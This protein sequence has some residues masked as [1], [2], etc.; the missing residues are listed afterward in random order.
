MSININ[1]NNNSIT[2]NFLLIFLFYA[3]SLKRHAHKLKTVFNN[4]QQS[5]THFTDYSITYIPGFKIINTNFPD[6]TAH[7]GIVIYVK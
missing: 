7:S 2:I 1:N 5:E 3:N 6:K 4:I